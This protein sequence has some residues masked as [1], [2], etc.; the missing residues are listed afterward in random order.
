MKSASKVMYTIGRVFNIIAIVLFAILL[1]FGIV[2]AATPDKIVELSEDFAE[3]DA[4]RAYGVTLIIVAAIFLIIY[5]V[6]CGLAGHARKALNNGRTDKAPHIIMIIVGVFGDIFYLLGGIFG[7]VAEREEASARDDA[8]VEEAP[9]AEEV[10][11]EPAEDSEN[12]DNE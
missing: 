2:F 6:I 10:P 1:I 12:K 7:L 8:P 3:A 11:E 9:A 5:S 4:A